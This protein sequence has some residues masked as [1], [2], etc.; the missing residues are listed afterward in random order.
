MGRKL[1]QFCYFDILLTLKKQQ[2]TTRIEFKKQNN[3]VR[4]KDVRL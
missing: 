2:K 1:D 4:Q 3:N